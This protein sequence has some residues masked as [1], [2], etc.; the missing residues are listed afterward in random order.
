MSPRRAPS[1][2]ERWEIVAEAVYITCDTLLLSK[3][4]TGS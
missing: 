1:D 3:T 4:V 2:V